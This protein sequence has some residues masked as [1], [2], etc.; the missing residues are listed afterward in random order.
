M[1]GLI[2]LS[3]ADVH[4]WCA[5]AEFWNRTPGDL[6][7][8][9]MARSRDMDVMLACLSPPLTRPDIEETLLFISD[10][11]RKH[12]VAS[13][14]CQIQ[15]VLGDEPHDSRP[16]THYVKELPDKDTRVAVLRNS[17]LIAALLRLCF[18][19]LASS[20]QHDDLVLNFTAFA[21]KRLSNPI[22]SH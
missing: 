18:R 22:H 12:I 13:V 9:L 16:L 21:P 8:A 20:P 7:S 3:L 2:G 19:A 15:V 4:C 14:L 10:I 6:Q 5:V 17:T 1:C 11:M